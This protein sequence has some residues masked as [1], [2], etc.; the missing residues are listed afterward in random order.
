MSALAS[1]AEFLADRLPARSQATVPHPEDAPV[2][3]LSFPEATCEMAEQRRA[4][5]PDAEEGD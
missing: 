1:P 2:T 4:L 5:T 3:H